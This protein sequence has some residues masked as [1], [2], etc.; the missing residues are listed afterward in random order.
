MKRSEIKRKTPMART[1]ILRT[2]SV[3]L[4]A[5]VKPITCKGC[6]KK[7]EPFRPGAKVCSPDCGQTFA[8]LLREKAERAEA[9]RDR[10][11]DLRRRESLKTLAD[12]IAD[13]QRIFNAYI[14][15]RDKDL[16]CICCGRF[17]GEWSRGGIWDAGHYR[18]RG[19]AG[20]LRFNEA[21][22]HRQLK[23]CNN[24][25]AGRHAEYRIGLIA[26]IGLAAVEALEADQAIHKW[27]VEELK[28]LQVTYRAKLKELKSDA[29]LQQ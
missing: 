29:L 17:G 4:S 16:P 6:R 28:A 24:F 18:S 3:Q 8:R 2:A 9:K 19:S 21:N 26:R 12:H 5:V 25:G 27:T 7:K 10:A 1:G 22:V 15:F 14:R 20:H 23:Q 13:T 11:D